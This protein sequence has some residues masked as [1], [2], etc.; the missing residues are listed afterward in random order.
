MGNKFVILLIGAILIVFISS[1]GFIRIINSSSPVAISRQIGQQNSQSPNPSLSLKPSIVSI[2]T[3][4]AKDGEHLY[5]LEPRNSEEAAPRWKIV[6]GASP[7]TLVRVAGSENPVVLEANQD[8]GTLVYGEYWK[9]ET[10]VY[11][12]VFLENAPSPIAFQ[13]INGSDPSTFSFIP[14]TS[15]Y[16]SS[17]VKDGRHVFYVASDGEATEV[18]GADPSTFRFDDTGAQ[19]DGRDS[20]QC[21]F[22]GFVSS[23]LL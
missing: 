19:W 15:F 22:R 16:R 12:L 11:V 8:D 18:E 6:A 4:L 23:C 20:A 14:T 13:K 1:I 10:A 2:A 7:Q 5:V 3:Y 17:Y 9:D 21:Y